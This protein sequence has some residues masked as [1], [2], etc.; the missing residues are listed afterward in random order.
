MGD[1]PTEERE[2]VPK[3]RAGVLKALG[4]KPMQWGGG[5]QLTEAL[6]AA[7]RPA[8][9]KEQWDSGKAS[10]GYGYSDV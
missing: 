4:T 5:W 7:R 9:G 1:V 2:S 3:F 6:Q 10:T 8:F